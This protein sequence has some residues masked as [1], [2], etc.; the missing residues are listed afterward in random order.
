M[1]VNS[2]GIKVM[3]V[4]PGAFK[5]DIGRAGLSCESRLRGR[6]RP[7]FNVVCAC[8]I[9]SRKFPRPT[10]SPA[11]LVVAIAQNPNPKLCYLVGRDARI[12]LAMKR[13]L[14]WKCTRR[15]VSN[16]LKID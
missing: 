16:F 14:P 2:L 10:R 3:L 11:Q 4:E 1:E 15:L 8:G 5:T 9:A 6:R 7:I 13:I 12:Q